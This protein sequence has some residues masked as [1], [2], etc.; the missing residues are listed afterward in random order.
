MMM[1]TP[2]H[3]PKF[4]PL[5]CSFLLLCSCSRGGASKGGMSESHGH[6]QY[7]CVLLHSTTSCGRAIPSLT[8]TPPLHVHDDPPQTAPNYHN[9]LNSRA[10]YTASITVF[11]NSQDTA[12]K[13]P[14]MTLKILIKYKNMLMQ[15][16][17]VKK[18]LQ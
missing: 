6:G 16:M 7:H 15:H 5:A 13:I 1:M 11:L 9:K 10:K 14:R 17:C 3:N 4:I 2:N 8:D 18:T 12:A